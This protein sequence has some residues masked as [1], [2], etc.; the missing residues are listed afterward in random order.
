MVLEVELGIQ[1]ANENI[2]NFRNL[3][4]KFNEIHHC[5]TAR[6]VANSV[7]ICSEWWR[8]VYYAKIQ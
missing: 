7:A 1:A 8:F 5:P 6:F 4:P 3:N 2:Q